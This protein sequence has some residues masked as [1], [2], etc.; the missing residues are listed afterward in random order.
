MIKSLREI[1]AF[2]VLI[3]CLYL[4][5]LLLTV[6]LQKE[7]ADSYAANARVIEKQLVRRGITTKRKLLD[8]VYI[9]AFLQ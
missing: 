9:Y 6:Y 1:P 3:V 8:E 7:I 2:K 5:V 4:N